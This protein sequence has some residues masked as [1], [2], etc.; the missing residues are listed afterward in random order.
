MLLAAEL[1]SEWQ[2][3]SG[4]QLRNFAVSEYSAAHA[5]EH[6][7][8]QVQNCEFLFHGL[9]P[10]RNVMLASTHDLP[11]TLNRQVTMT[12]PAATAIA[13]SAARSLALIDQNSSHIEQYAS[14][15]YPPRSSLSKELRS[16]PG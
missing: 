13:T 11:Q 2:A 3:I 6:H 1:P 5:N 10:F 4:A 14:S 15:G 7:R 12:A 8:G 9:Y 16:Y